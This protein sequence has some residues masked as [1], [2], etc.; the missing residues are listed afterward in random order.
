LNRDLALVSSV[1]VSGC[2]SMFV[3]FLSL[4]CSRDIVYHLHGLVVFST[5]ILAGSISLVLFRFMGACFVAL[6]IPECLANCVGDSDS[7]WR[8]CIAHDLQVVVLYWLKWLACGL[9]QLVSHIRIKWVARPRSPLSP[10]GS[11]G[12]P[13]L[14][15]QR[16]PLGPALQDPTISQTRSKFPKGTLSELL[17]LVFGLT[18]FVRPGAGRKGGR[19]ETYLFVVVVSG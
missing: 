5:A 10:K 17:G 4:F 8:C 3:G 15:H 11:A 16:A 9:L 1:S 14:S 19:P 18:P 7:A 2:C 13:L 6:L 12:P